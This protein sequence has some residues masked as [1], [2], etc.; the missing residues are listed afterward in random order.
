MVDVDHRFACGLF[1]PPRKPFFW[2]RGPPLFV[3]HPY[4]TVVKPLYYLLVS[5][6]YYRI[7]NAVDIAITKEPYLPTHASHVMRLRIACDAPLHCVIDWTSLTPLVKSVDLSVNS[8][9]YFFFYTLLLTLVSR[10]AKRKQH[11]YTYRRSRSFTYPHDIQV[12][13]VCKAYVL[14][15]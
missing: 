11:L 8:L 1:A 10:F 4:Y 12:I 13:Q 3:N 6:L 14:C 15:K 9:D 5:M 7:V 2:H